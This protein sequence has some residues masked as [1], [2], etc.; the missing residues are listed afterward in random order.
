MLGCIIMNSIEILEPSPFPYMY[1]RRGLIG[2]VFFAQ[3]ISFSIG[4]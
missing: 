2:Y 3:A 4:W 1:T